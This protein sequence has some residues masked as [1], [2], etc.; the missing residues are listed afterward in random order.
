M[1]HKNSYQL[2][3]YFYQKKTWKLSLNF[4]SSELL[5]DFT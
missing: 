4:N 3:N 1:Y 2:G 5:C